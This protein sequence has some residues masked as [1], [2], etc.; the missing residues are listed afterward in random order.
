M[1]EQQAHCTRSAVLDSAL[2]GGERVAGHV[3]PHNRSCS[4]YRVMP[5]DSDRL[6]WLADAV[7]IP[8]GPWLSG[9][10]WSRAWRVFAALHTGYVLC[11]PYDASVGFTHIRPPSLSVRRPELRRRS[12]QARELNPFDNTHPMATTSPISRSGGKS[13]LTALTGPSIS[14]PPPGKAKPASYHAR[15]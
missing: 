12:A 3:Q 14:S 10:K 6:V 11:D 2:Q 5:S 15:C 9:D 4:P 13:A 1:H 8:V 7:I